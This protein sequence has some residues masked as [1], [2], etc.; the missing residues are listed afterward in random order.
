MIDT[1]G[2]W[3]VLDTAAM[4]GKRQCFDVLGRLVGRV[5][6]GTAVGFMPTASCVLELYGTLV[7]SSLSAAAC[8]LNFAVM[9]SAATLACVTRNWSLMRVVLHSHTPMMHSDHP[10]PDLLI[11]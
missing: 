10:P 4:C 5:G 6:F 7:R 2:R 8:G 9:H 11:C 3:V 1:T